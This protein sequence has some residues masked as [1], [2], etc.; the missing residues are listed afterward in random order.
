MSVPAVKLQVDPA[1]TGVWD[2]TQYLPSNTIVA[3]DRPVEIQEIAQ[4]YHR[5]M[6]AG[7][8]LFDVQHMLEAIGR[9]RQVH[10]SR[11]GGASTREDETIRFDV[12]S[13][14][15][16]E[17]KADDAV[18]ELVNLA[19]THAVSVFCDNEGERHRLEALVGQHTEEIDA[20]VSIQYVA[21]GI[22]RGFEWYDRKAIFV[23]CHEIF[24]R[25]RTRRRL[26]RVYASRAI[27]SWVDL[28]PG[29]HVV[30]AT[31][32][33]AVYQGMQTMRKHEGGKLEEFLV[34]EFAEKANVFVPASQIDLVQKYI[35]AAGTK[36][37]LSKLGGKR[38]KRTRERV[39]GAVEELAENLL[40]NQAMRAQQEGTRYPDD[41]EWQREF[42]AAFPFEETEDQLIVAGEVRD[43]LTSTRPMDRLICGDVGYGKTE[44]AMR[45][46][47]KVVEYGRQVAVLVPTTV[48][49]EQ[50]YETFQQRFAQYPFTFGCLSRFRSTAEQKKIVDG[51]RRG[52]VDVV[53]GTHRI[54]SKDVQFANLGLVIVDEEQRFGV[55]HKER[56]KDFSQTV[57]VITLSATPIPRTL[58]M[59]MTGIRDIS[60]LQTPPVDR[61]A[62]ATHTQPFSASLVREAIMRELDRDGQVFFVHNFVKSIHAM[63]ERVHAIV[64]EA[65][66]LVGHGQMKERELEDVMYRFAHREADVLVSTTIIESGIDIPTANTIFIDRA[67]RFGLAELHQLRGRVGR[68]SHRGYCYLLLPADRP[69]PPKAMRRLKAI[70]EFS[71]L[72]AGFRIAMRDLELRGAGNILGPEQSGHIASVGYD[73][74]CKML[75][76]AV[77]KLKHEPEAATHEVHLELGVAGAHSE[78]LYRVG[79][80]AHGDL[81]PAGRF[82]APFGHSAARAGSDGRIRYATPPGA[83]TGGTGRASCQG[84]VVRHPVDH[85]ATARC[86]VQHREALARAGIVHRHRRFRAVAG[87]GTRFICACRSATSSQGP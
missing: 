32:G 77:R 58:H 4:A 47:F 22:H 29:E 13:L 80:R 37:Q 87:R 16:F 52:R 65:R 40:R 5:R 62:I 43:D 26:R 59:A 54:L 70:E 44:L 78:Q 25:P 50:H 66:I 48:L 17:G 7:D 1:R 15:R 76:R 9:F 35:G 68:S 2:F 83:A 55:E 51:A 46:V 12:R 21:Y 18:Q 30:H 84:S 53:I 67:E 56:L 38:W 74:Y 8:K 49:A 3:L 14:T 85:P 10:L 86:R 27:D 39:E 36:P 23:G 6:N 64:P 34:L 24:H 31:H 33:I 75:E 61:R 69:I 82:P 60:T 79:V 71:D 57:D 73:L 41:T 42:E 28:K 63:A 81:P 45:A 11:F 20:D 19:K 72:G